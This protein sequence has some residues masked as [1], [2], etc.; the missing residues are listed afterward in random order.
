MRGSGGR[1]PVL[2][3]LVGGLL[4]L[5][6]CA[7]L[8]AMDGVV[9]GGGGGGMYGG[10]VY[11][12]VVDGQVRS[13]D[14]RRSR[15]ELRDHRNRAQTLRIDRNTQ[16]VYRQRSYP[17]S[18]LERGDVVRVRASRDRDGRLWADRIDVRESVRERGYGYARVERVSGTVG[19]V[20]RRS[21]TFVVQPSRSQGMIVQLPHQLRREDAR[22]YERLR[23][24]DRVQVEV[25]PVGGGRFELVRFR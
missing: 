13:V 6:A 23:R 25:V 9:L 4:V 19:G 16:L 22:R 24:G 12:T 1:L 3:T 2:V 11:A 5:P 10:G 17:V 7:P 21:G 18:A 15:V 14:L 8:G 20:D